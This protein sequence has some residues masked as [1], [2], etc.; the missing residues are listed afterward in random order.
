MD[1]PRTNGSLSVQAALDLIGRDV[2]ANQPQPWAPAGF[3]LERDRQL[4]LLT[5]WVEQHQLWLD[6]SILGEQKR[7]RM[8]HDIFRPEPFAGTVFKATKGQ[9]FGFWPYCPQNIVSS[10]AD[11]CFEMRPATPAQYLQRLHLMYQLTPGLNGLAGF[12]HLNGL[13][14]IVTTQRWYDARNAT[15]K[16]INT[17]LRGMGFKPVRSD[18]YDDPTRWFHPT[19]NIAL[20]DVGQSNILICGDEL[21]PI[22]IVPIIPDTFM[23]ERLIEFMKEA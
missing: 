17:Y 20:F 5:P 10:M 9:K 7:G 21:V 13:F 22:D 23:R 8:E 11:E 4:A 15:W 18:A 19:Q 2:G 16:E 14:S 12:T 6:T 1:D 3:A